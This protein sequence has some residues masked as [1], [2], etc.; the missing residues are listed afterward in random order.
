MGKFTYSTAAL[1]EDEARLLA[2][3]FMSR[4]WT[5]KARVKTITREA[6]NIRITDAVQ[7]KNGI[8]TL[9]GTMTPNI[10]E[11]ANVE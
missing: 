7:D 11:V 10:T 3:A 1:D 8:W 5:A 2:K 9:T 6:T 4:T